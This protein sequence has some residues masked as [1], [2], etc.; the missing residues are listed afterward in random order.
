MIVGIPVTDLRLN[1][2]DSK[3]VQGRMHALRPSLPQDALDLLAAALHYDPEDRPQ[4]AE[5][6][7]HV[8]AAHLISRVLPAVESNR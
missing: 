1:E 3:S 4:D 7:V 2:S 8:L 5:D 6:F